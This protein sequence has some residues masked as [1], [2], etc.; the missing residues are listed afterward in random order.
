MSPEGGRAPGLRNIPPGAP[1]RRLP[2]EPSGHG[3]SHLYAYI[4]GEQHELGHDRRLSSS[5]GW[6]LDAMAARTNRD[7]TMRG[8]LRELAKD[9]NRGITTVRYHVERLIEFGFVEELGTCAEDQRH[10]VWRIAG[11]D[12]RKEGEASPGDNAVPAGRIRARGGRDLHLETR[13]GGARIRPELPEEL[14]KKDLA[15]PQQEPLSP[16]D[17]GRA[18]DPIGIRVAREASAAARR[19][20][21][22]QGGPEPPAAASDGSV[23]PEPV[24][25]AQNATEDAA[26]GTA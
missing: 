7:G 2:S 1:T 20:R 24:L 23:A 19:R 14:H 3:D 13:E 8:S 16:R 4:R 22:A 9:L 12:R 11:M 10:R 5:D 17:W 21:D 26:E 18:N 15:S 25:E 6:Y